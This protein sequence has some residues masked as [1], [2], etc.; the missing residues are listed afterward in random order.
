MGQ[1]QRMSPLSVMDCNI[2]TVHK[3]HPG[4]TLFGSEKVRLKMLG[5]IVVFLTADEPKIT[6]V[7]G[8]HLF[9]VFY[10]DGEVF[11]FHWYNVY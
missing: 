2:G 6:R 3:F 11:Y 10:P 7:E 9:Q 8:T 5:G 1:A 4:S